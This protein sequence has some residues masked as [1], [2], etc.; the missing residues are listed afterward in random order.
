MNF[1]LFLIVSRTTDY[2]LYRTF[3][4]IVS[5]S[6]YLLRWMTL[7]NNVYNSRPWCEGNTVNISSASDSLHEVCY[8][9]CARQPAVCFFYW[10]YQKLILYITWKQGCFCS[11]A[12]AKVKLLYYF[13]LLFP[14]CWVLFSDDG[15]GSSVQ[16]GKFY[17]SPRVFSFLSF[18]YVCN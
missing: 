18:L 8:E 16:N 5:I 13:L 10:P 15:F 11:C 17:I 1:A 2:R 4:H 12:L 7:R 9:V 3:F 6:V 14:S